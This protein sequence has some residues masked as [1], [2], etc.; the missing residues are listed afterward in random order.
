MFFDPF[1]FALA[2][3]GS[4]ASSSAPAVGTA[5]CRLH[6]P[7]A[8]AA[9]ASPPAP[10]VVMLHGCSQSPDDFAAG[11]RM[12][13]LA[14]AHGFVVAYPG[15]TSSANGANCWN[16][17]KAEHHAR[18]GGEPA[19]IAALV[20]EITAT[21]RI[22]PL[23]I[24]I[25][26][27]SA[28]A[29]MAVIA[30]ETYP[31]VFAAVCAHSG[32]PY[33]AADDLSGA[34]AAMGNGSALRGVSSFGARRRMRRAGARASAHHVPTMVFHGDADATINVRNG[35][36]IAEQAAFAAQSRAHGP[37]FLRRRVQPLTFAGGRTGERTVYDDAAGR[38]A[39]EQ[40]L[41]HGAGHAWSGGS[42]EG[43]FT[44][45]DGPDASAEMV[46]FFL[47]QRRDASPSR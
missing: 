15:Q 44:D 47:S 31:D 41:L 34:F 36:E 25:A 13:A 33:A 32:L 39:V 43:S 28:G 22:D 9:P 16:W 8:C 4:A 40:W 45:P 18:D 3:T 2:P 46:R 24:Y 12:D 38:P 5:L 7:A 10:L 21:C 37:L 30:A 26:G 17:F 20:R 23:R 35:M 42:S 1:F 14:D 27:M 6:V 29:A 11:T 19:L